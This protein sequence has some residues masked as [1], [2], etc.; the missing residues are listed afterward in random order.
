M[1][2]HRLAARDLGM[3]DSSMPVCQRRRALPAGRS[4]K[5]AIGWPPGVSTLALCQVFKNIRCV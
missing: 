4:H 5:V 2:A 3:W 1:H